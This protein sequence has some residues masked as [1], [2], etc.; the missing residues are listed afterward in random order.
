MYYLY[1]DESGDPGP[2]RDGDG[3]VILRSSRFFT[4]SGILVNDDVKKQF[5]D[6]YK[7]IMSTYFNRFTIPPGFKLHFNS[8]RMQK[9]YPYDSLT[10][11]ERLS[12]ENDVLSTVLNLDCKTMSITLDLD[13]HYQQ[14]ENP[15][16]PVAL[17]LLYALERFDDFKIQNQ[18]D[19]VAIFEK[20]T[21]SMRDKVQREWNKLRGIANFPHADPWPDLD[22]VKNGDP[23]LEPIL[24]YADFFGYIPYFRKKAIADWNTFTRKYHDFYERNFIS[25]NA[26]YP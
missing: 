6:E 17:A 12:L 1:L 9:K 19:G 13:H 4:L 22:L 26:E 14:Y 15:V 18:V 2:Y 7:K 25:W 5:E 24:A 10:E 16:W 20:F 3:Q 11:N 21:N 23:C 8:L